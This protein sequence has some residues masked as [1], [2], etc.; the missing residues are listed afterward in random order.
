VKLFSSQFNDCWAKSFG[1]VKRYVQ[2]YSLW[3]E[4]KLQFS[5]EVYGTIAATQSQE[6]SVCLD[7]VQ[8]ILCSFFTECSSK[9]KK[10]KV[11]QLQEL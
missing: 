6:V 2:K 8:V 5:K 9:I 7:Q 10:R 3:P 1:H 11:Q 4:E